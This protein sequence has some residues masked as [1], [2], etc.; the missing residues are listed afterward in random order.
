[1]EEVE[2]QEGTFK[3]VVIKEEKMLKA[4]VKED[5]N[6]HMEVG[7]KGAGNNGSALNRFMK[8][9]K[10]ISPSSTQYQQGIQG[11]LGRN[12]NAVNSLGQVISC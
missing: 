10:D 4:N 2:R 11:K 12:E 5:V 6:T 8:Q 9:V 3:K 7:G 1:M